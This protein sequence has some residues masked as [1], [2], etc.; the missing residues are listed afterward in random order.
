MGAALGEF[1]PDPPRISSVPYTSNEIQFL[2]P[3][4]E[5]GGRVRLDQQRLGDLADRW[6]ALG[7]APPDREHQLVL[8]MG[9]PMRLGGL[10]T[11]LVETS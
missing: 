10:A 8:T 3:I 2:H 5:L 1:E 4:N 11:P 6:P 9:Q 7:L